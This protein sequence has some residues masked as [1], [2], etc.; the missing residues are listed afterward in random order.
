MIELSQSDWLWFLMGAI[1]IGMAKTGLGGLGMLVVPIMASVFGAKESTGIV[2]PMLIMA[3]FFGVGYYHRHADMRQLLRL[4][5]STIAGV[6]FAIWVGDAIAP[7]QFRML[8]AFIIIVGS[9]IMIFNFRN[10]EFIKPNKVTAL[11]AGF[12]GGFTTMIG[13]A[14]GPVM[15]VYFLAMGFQKNKFIGTAAWFFLLVNLFKVP[16]HIWVWETITWETFQLN[17]WIIPAIVVGALVGFRITRGIPERPYRAFIIV[18]ILL[19][20]FKLFF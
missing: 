17:L 15:S 5:P 3:D 10:P 12:L 6:F 14:A 19:A 11:I 4:V 18:G 2:L 1:F 8:L 7:D 16:F 9:A 13:N 20:A